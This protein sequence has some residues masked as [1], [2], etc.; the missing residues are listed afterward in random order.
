M[1]ASLNTNPNVAVIMPVFNE[2]AT[3]EAVLRLVLAQ[4][5]VVEVVV[6]DDCTTV[7]HSKC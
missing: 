4:S 7:A 6:V 5:C 1:S 3:V 2:R